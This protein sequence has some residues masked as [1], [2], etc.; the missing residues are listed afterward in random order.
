MTPKQSEQARTEITV[1]FYRL[2]SGACKAKFH[3]WGDPKG[4][5]TFPRDTW[6][7]VCK[8]VAKVLDEHLN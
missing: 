3:N 6:E 1:T 4:S 2:D 5:A 7:G 8:Q